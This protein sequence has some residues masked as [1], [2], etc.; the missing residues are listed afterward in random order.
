MLK[1]ASINLQNDKKVV[2]EAVKHNEDGDILTQQ[3]LFL[4]QE[5]IN[6][7]II[8]REK[9]IDKLE[10]NVMLQLVLLYQ[11]IKVFP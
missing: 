4:H 5:L 3:L 2:L 8:R 7:I 10:K 11:Q 1:Y 6:Q 9:E